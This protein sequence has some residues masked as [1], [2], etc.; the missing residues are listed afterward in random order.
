MRAT[1]AGTAGMVKKC[2]YFYPVLP[3]IT[4]FIIHDEVMSSDI[5]NALTD[6]VKI[7]LAA[8]V[9]HRAFTRILWVP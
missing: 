8:N 3:L 6:V 1:T 5:Q 7:L 4:Y 2:D 9:I